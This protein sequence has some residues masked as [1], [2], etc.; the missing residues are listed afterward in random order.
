MLVGSK[1][2]GPEQHC[3]ATPKTTACQLFERD[4][5]VSHQPAYVER[6]ENDLE[7]AHTN[8][9]AEYQLKTAGGGWG[10][11]IK[12][13]DNDQTKTELGQGPGAILTKVSFQCDLPAGFANWRNIQHSDKSITKLKTS[14]NGLDS[15]FEVQCGNEN[16]QAFAYLEKHKDSGVQQVKNTYYGSTWTASAE[17]GKSKTSIPAQLSLLDR[18]FRCDRDQAVNCSDEHASRCQCK[19]DAVIKNVKRH[20]VLC[21][22]KCESENRCYLHAKAAK[23]EAKAAGLFDAGSNAMGDNFLTKG[24][25]NMGMSA[26]NIRGAHFSN[27]ACDDRCGGPKSDDNADYCIKNER[28]K[29]K[30]WG[31]E[32]SQGSYTDLFGMVCAS[33]RRCP[34]E[35]LERAMRDEECKAPLDEECKAAIQECK[36]SLVRW[37]CPASVSAVN[38][39]KRT[40][41]MA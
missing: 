40:V 1:V 18:N 11:T 33:I 10:N 23:V 12:P 34:K 6:L 28:W 31:K 38:R 5:Q 8:V 25:A 3:F 37:R 24:A 14:S 35:I 7:W 9:V 32:P 26:A 20:C 22:G 16:S 39:A 29:Q 15:N 17:S 36:A 21:D 4:G 27:P 30:G 19:Y 41:T 13:I 2:E